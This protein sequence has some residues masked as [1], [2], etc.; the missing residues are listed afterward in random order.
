M[1]FA[2]DRS[3]GAFSDSWYNTTLHAVDATSATELWTKSGDNRDT[4][5]PVA[6]DGQVIYSDNRGTFCYDDSGVKLWE[7]ESYTSRKPLI[8]GDTVYLPME[9]SILGLSMED[10][11]QKQTIQSVPTSPSLLAS[12]ESAI[13][14]GT[15]G[16]ALRVFE[17]G[18]N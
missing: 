13:Y 11:S 1:Y 6:H 14:I 9:E 16:G 12:D 7:K 8:Q 10:G 3:P 5:V 2:R 4:G 15:T 18:G 17:R